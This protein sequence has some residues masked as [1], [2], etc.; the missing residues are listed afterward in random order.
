M[1]KKTIVLLLAFAC[2]FLLAGCEAETLPVEITVYFYEGDDL[3][4]TITVDSGQSLGDRMPGAPDNSAAG[5]VFLGWFDGETQYTAASVINTSIGW[6]GNEYTGTS[7]INTS[8]VLLARWGISGAYTVAFNSSGGS[9]VSSIEVLRGGSM[10]VRYPVPT[11]WGEAFEGWFA[12]DGS[13]YTRSTPIQGNIA[14]TARWGADT[15]PA[16]TLNFIDTYTEYS[17]SVVVHE[18]DIMGFRLPEPPPRID[19]DIDLRFFTGWRF[20]GWSFAGG[21][22]EAARN[23]EW[24]TPV[25]Q[26]ADLTARWGVS[27]IPETWELDLEGRVRGSARV[28]A[29]AE[30]E[31][32]ENGENKKLTV[33][34]TGSDQVVT[35]RLPQ[36]LRTQLLQQRGGAYA[37]E[38]LTIEIDGESNPA[39]RMF[40]HVVGNMTQGSNWNATEPSSNV[41]FDELSEELT[42]NFMSGNASNST[43]EAF[44]IQARNSTD[45]LEAEPSVVTIRSVKISIR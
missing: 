26:D 38:A 4:N 41:I 32:D 6:L 30:Y 35:F 15:R 8:L 12:D 39:D 2:S 20:L 37:V 13:E 9:P 18:G 24:D 40:R 10:G 45:M 33:T 3:L 14:L 23:F 29:E 17:N 25:M 19:P 7:V 27:I 42:G 11:K 5:A 16:Y 21:A 1:N 22:G 28:S 44:I 43:N 31:E 34:F 36:R